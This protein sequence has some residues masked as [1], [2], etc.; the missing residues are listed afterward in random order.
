MA[1]FIGLNIEEGLVEQIFMEDLANY[2]RGYTDY[3]R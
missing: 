1:G 3:L 2:N